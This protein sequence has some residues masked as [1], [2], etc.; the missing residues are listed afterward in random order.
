MRDVG[1]KISILSAYDY[2]TVDSVIGILDTVCLLAFVM[3]FCIRACYHSWW[4]GPDAVLRNPWMLLDGCLV[5]CDTVSTI[6]TVSTE[7]EKL[8]DFVV[9]P[10][11]KELQFGGIVP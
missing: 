11:I 6:T 7:R 8:D 4:I 2:D 1:K 5:V 9:E 10:M 3:E